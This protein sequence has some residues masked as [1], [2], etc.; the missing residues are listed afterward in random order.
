MPNKGFAWKYKVGEYTYYLVTDKQKVDNDTV[1]IETE[2]QDEEHRKANCFMCYP[3]YVYTSAM[4]GYT[5]VTSKEAKEVDYNKGGGNLVTVKIGIGTPGYPSDMY[6][7]GVSGPGALGYEGAPRNVCYI[8]RESWPFG[9]NFKIEFTD[10]HDSIL[11]GPY[12]FGPYNESDMTKVF[13]YDTNTNRVVLVNGMEGYAI[14]ET[15]GEV[16]GVE[17]FRLRL[18]WKGMS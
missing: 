12:Y 16:D 14:T 1:M 18:E 10:E 13:R 7:V 4:T 3:G 17:A 9:V 5:E 11:E 15:D 8:K 2:T 6:F